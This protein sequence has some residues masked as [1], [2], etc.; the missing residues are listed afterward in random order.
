MWI[1]PW[2]WAKKCGNIAPHGKQP[3][4]RPPGQ[5]S[6]HIVQN[7]WAKANNIPGYNENKAPSILLDS[8]KHSVITARQNTRRRERV[9]A[10]QGRWSTSGKDEVRNSYSDLKAA[11]VSEK[12]ARRASSK[13]YKYF[14]EL[15]V[16]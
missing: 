7:H 14:D 5:Q 4:P 6:H 1:D 12:E 9:A 10:H 15:G 13:A 16:L 2:G 3:S 8:K 11:G